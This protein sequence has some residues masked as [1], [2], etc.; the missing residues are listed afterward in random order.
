MTQTYSDDFIRDILSETKTVALV[1]YSEKPERASNK[2]ANFLADKGYRVIAVNPGLAGQA[3]RGEPIVGS[4][5]E[6][7]EGEPVDMVDIFRRSEAVG[8][9]VDAA[10]A[11]LSGLKTVWMQVGIENAEAQAAAE[12]KGVK[13]VQDRCPK[14]EHPRLIG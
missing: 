14:I 9:V 4:L 6:I 7:P 11:H 1:G 13:V 12:A 8:P 2:V 3:F 10:L 5:A